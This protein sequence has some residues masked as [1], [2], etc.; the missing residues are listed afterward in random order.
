[1]CSFVAAMAVAC[2]ASVA[3]A[4]REVVVDFEQFASEMEPNSAWGFGFPLRLGTDTTTKS[5]DGND[6]TTVTYTD[7]GVSFHV[8]Y[9]ISEAEW[10]GEL[11][12]FPFWSGIGLSNK[13]TKA[14]GG[15]YSND[16]DLYVTGGAPPNGSSM[17]AVVFGSARSQEYYNSFDAWQYEW[18]PYISLPNNVTLQSMDIANTANAFSYMN[19]SVHEGWQHTWL[20]SDHLTLHIYGIANNELI[21]YMDY[22]LASL[23][24]W[25][26]IDFV[27]SVLWSWSDLDELRFAF[28]SSDIGW[29]GLNAP[30]YFA[31]TN[32]TY[33]SSA[34]IPEPATLAILG[35]GLT[36]LALIRRRRK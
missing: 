15:W 26:T 33:S 22:N 35:L 9:G 34:A 27:D 1:M 6:Q 8:N 10:D 4:Q 5:E 25:K 3:Y 20:A 28:T 14:E 21:A 36:G 7:K 17:Y 29:Y 13:T 23:E 12:T 32:L 16:N 19:D 24:G 31:F 30:T 11:Y 18:L 2:F